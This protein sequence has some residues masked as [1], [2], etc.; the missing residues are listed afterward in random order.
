[1]AA[2]SDKASPIMIKINHQQDHCEEFLKQLTDMRSQE[3]LTD[4]LIKSGDEEIA[5]H[6]V[7]LAAHSA[8][9][10]H[11]FKHKTTQEVKQG[12]VSLTELHFP[13]LQ[14][15]IDFCYSGTMKFEVGLSERVIEVIDYLQIPTMKSA[16]ASLIIHHLT[17]DN[18]IDWYFFAS[19][20]DMTEVKQK[21]HEIMCIDFGSAS[22][23]P[24]FF[25][26]DYNDLVAYVTWKEVH[27]DSALDAACRWVM[28]D[29]QQRQNKFEDILQAIN[30]TRCSASCLSHIMTTYGT[31]LTREI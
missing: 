9:F 13:A 29:K 14:V 1:M 12:F 22:H 31:D 28:H 18:C 21:A 3:H 11:M 8:Y 17:V 19:M 7:I 6:K 4:F 25:A 26:L 15:V 24:A 10:R 16:I 2:N 27:C 5:C 23:L 30:I 20:Y